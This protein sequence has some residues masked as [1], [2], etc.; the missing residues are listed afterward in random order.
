M[1]EQEKRQKLAMMLRAVF[2]GALLVIAGS[3]LSAFFPGEGM[4]LAASGLS[5]AY[6]L[7]IAAAMRGAAQ[8]TGD[9]DYRYAVYTAAINAACILLTLFGVY[10]Y[11]F[12]AVLSLLCEAACICYL[13]RGTGTAL[14]AIGR[15]DTARTGELLWK[16]YAGCEAGYAVMLFVPLSPMLSALVV[17]AALTVNVA[18]VNYLHSAQK[19]LLQ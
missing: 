17:A 9:E 4:M 7:T 2:F 11:G 15:D 8:T 10:L 14:R 1:T 18:F 19:A 12:C 5:F 16:L 6:V 3:F 13:C